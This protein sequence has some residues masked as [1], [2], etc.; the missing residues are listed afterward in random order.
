MNTFNDYAQYYNLLYRDKDYRSE[1]NFVDS[2]LH[3]YSP[4]I[5]TILDL[6]CGTGRHGFVLAQMGHA[7]TGVDHSEQMLNVANA[8]LQ[9]KSI[10]H[11]HLDIR[12]HLSDIQMLRLNQQFDCI[13]S[14]F[15]VASYHSKNEDLGAFFDTVQRHLRPNGGLLIFDFWYGPAVLSEKPTVRIKRM[16]DED[17]KIIRIAEPT[18]HP[19]DNTVEINITLVVIDKKT[20]TAREIRETHWMRYLFLPEIKTLLY[21][22]QLEIC[23]IAEWETGKAP[24]ADTWD[25]YCVAQSL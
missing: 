16:E 18:M 25:L 20:A 1:V 10:E 11:G 7:V 15:H 13:L 4:N 9:A 12:F 6:G 23:E 22:A 21:E 5:Q 14:L 19:Y 2:L 24:G 8:T 3:K 17:I